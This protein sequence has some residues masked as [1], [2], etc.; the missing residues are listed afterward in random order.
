MSVELRVEGK[1]FN[2]EVRAAQ[3]HQ[4][5]TWGFATGLTHSTFYTATFI[6]LIPTIYSSLLTHRLGK[7]GYKIGTQSGALWMEVSLV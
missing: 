5:C 3:V 7:I 6:H 2:V 4:R 1:V